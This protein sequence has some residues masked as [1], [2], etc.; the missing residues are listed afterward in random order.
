MCQSFATAHLVYQLKEV[1][2]II[3]ETLE[4]TNEA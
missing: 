1:G 4:I 3:E 2:L